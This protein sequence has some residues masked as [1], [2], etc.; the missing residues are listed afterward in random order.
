MAWR[1]ATQVHVV[2]HRSLL[3]GSAAAQILEG[4]SEEELLAGGAAWPCL[5]LLLKPSRRGPRYQTPQH[6]ICVP[7]RIDNV[8]CPSLPS[9]CPAMRYLATNT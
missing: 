2:L 7:L 3:D 4:L 5:W 8:G 9:R 1:F 6:P